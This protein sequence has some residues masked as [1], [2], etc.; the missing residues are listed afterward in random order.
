MSTETENKTDTT[1]TQTTEIKN[2]K[3]QLIEDEIKSY[4]IFINDLRGSLWKPRTQNSTYLDIIAIYLKGQKIIYIESKSHCESLLYRLMLPAIAIS[5]ICTVLSLATTSLNYGSI[6]VASLTS[7]NSFIL[8]I[9]SYLKLDGKAESYRVS[10]YKFEKLE[11]KCEFFSGKILYSNYTKDEIEKKM[12]DFIEQLEKDIEEI[13]EVNQFVIPQ[14]IRYKYPVLYSTN[15]FSEIKKRGNAERLYGHELNL[16]YDK[17]SKLVDKNPNM[18]DETK[19]IYNKLNQEKE[20]LLIMI[21]RQRDSYL[22]ID[23]DLTS[24][25]MDNIYKRRRSFFDYIFCRKGKRQT[26]DRKMPQYQKDVIDYI[27]R[28]HANISNDKEKN[29][30]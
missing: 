30:V 22:D 29:V 20:D 7:V 15:V 16:V 9:I 19:K 2:T 14:P 27:K 5:S 25:I 23:K 17:I 18:D 13:K 10:A 26:I 3:D 4:D 6:I 21:I 1:A 11:T 12:M 28:K 24:E 8:A